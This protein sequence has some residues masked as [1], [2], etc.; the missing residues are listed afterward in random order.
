MSQRGSSRRAKEKDGPDPDQSSK[1][2][3]KRPVGRGACAAFAAVRCAERPLGSPRCCSARLRYPARRMLYLALFECIVPAGDPCAEKYITT[4]AAA[5]TTVR[6]PE[7]SAPMPT[8]SPTPCFWFG[9][10]PGTAGI[11]P[12]C[13]LRESE[14][15]GAGRLSVQWVGFQR[16]TGFD[17]NEELGI[18]GLREDRVRG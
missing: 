3:E 4:S 11:R 10:R 7:F 18:H 6:T 2:T 12:R 1:L 15:R 9:F 14:A 13:H 16:S 17:L 5:R 8:H